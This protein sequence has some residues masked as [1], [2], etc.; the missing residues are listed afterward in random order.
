MRGDAQVLARAGMIVVRAIRAGAAAS[1]RFPGPR[2]AY[3]KYIYS[4]RGDGTSKDKGLGTGD[5]LRRLTREF[6]M[7]NKGLGRS[8]R[9]QVIDCAFI[10]CPSSGGAGWLC[11]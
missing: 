3:N 10:V 8:W 6:E 4:G 1:L 9:V 11:G 7:G 5:G 2:G